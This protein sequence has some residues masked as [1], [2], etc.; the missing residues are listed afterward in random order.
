MQGL[1]AV[2]LH[3]NPPATS[4]IENEN[5]KFQELN[6]FE[7]STVPADVKA[8]MIAAPQYDFSD[9][10]M[11]MLRDFWDKQGRIFIALDPAANDEAH[12]RT[13]DQIARLAGRLQRIEDNLEIVR[14]GNPD[15]GSLRKSRQRH[16]GLH[17]IAVA[18]QERQ[19]FASR[20]RL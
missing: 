9:R 8:I 6:F 7:V 18:S 3:I 10:E 19:Q 4:R 13:A 20:H 5:I 16:G 1:S 11:K 12:V 14:H 17:R 15:N 2:V